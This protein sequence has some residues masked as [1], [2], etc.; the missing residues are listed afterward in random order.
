MLIARYCPISPPILT[1]SLLDLTNNGV[2]FHDNYKKNIISLWT[3]NGRI[4][5]A[6]IIADV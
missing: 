4:E 2:L 3:W 5:I 6:R 1:K